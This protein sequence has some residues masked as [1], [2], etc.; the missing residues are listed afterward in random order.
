MS[1]TP[2]PSP[3]SPVYTLFDPRST[4]GAIILSATYGIDVKS[5]DDPFLNATLEASHTLAAALVPGKFLVDTVPL[6]R[7][8]CIQPE[9]TWS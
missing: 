3:K 1:Q 2:P 7:G 6:C 4:P 9:P 8:L 5:A